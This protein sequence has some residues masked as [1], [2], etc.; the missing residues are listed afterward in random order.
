MIS[1]RKNQLGNHRDKKD[2]CYFH[3][4]TN[5]RLRIIRTE[6]RYVIRTI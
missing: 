6:T 1:I 2:Y 4:N 3:R 5:G